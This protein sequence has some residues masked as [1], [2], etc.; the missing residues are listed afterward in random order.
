M[1]CTVCRKKTLGIIH[2][3]L[4]NIVRERGT[5]GGGSATPRANGFTHS[6]DKL[7]FDSICRH[8]AAMARAGA[9]DGTPAETP[10][11]FGMMKN[12]S[13]QVCNKILESAT[14]D[15]KES[16]PGCEADVLLAQMRKSAEEL[17]RTEQMLR[18]RFEHV[19]RIVMAITEH[20]DTTTDDL[21]DLH[22]ILSR[23]RATLTAMQV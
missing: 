12:L 3:S 17:A 18:N 4:M 14:T 2:R 23:C 1:S 5:D 16:K 22:A 8:L 13:K 19:S 21:S 6:L 11:P 10:E 9:E 20:D 15:T 7:I